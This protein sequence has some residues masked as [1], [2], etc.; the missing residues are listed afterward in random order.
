MSGCQCKSGF[1]A[2]RDCD[3]QVAG[4]CTV[5]QRAMCCRHSSPDSDLTYCLDCWAKKQQNNPADNPAAVGNDPAYNDQ[6]AYSY[7]NR[8]YAAG[9]A[10]IYYG[11]H[12]NRYY[13]TYDTRSFDQ[14]KTGDDDFTD[15]G[16]AG[17]GDS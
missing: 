10:P 2:L 1:F 11:S 17:F 7:R 4:R 3:Q 8:Y 15:D 13:D 6:W 14:A 12:Y 16:G 9:Y 5:C